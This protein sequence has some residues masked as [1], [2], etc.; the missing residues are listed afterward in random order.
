MIKTHTHVFKFVKRGSPDL[1][2]DERGKFFR[3]QCSPAERSEATCARKGFGE[4]NDAHF[5]V[6]KVTFVSVVLQR[7]A[8]L[9]YNLSETTWVPPI[10]I[11]NLSVQHPQSALDFKN[12]AQRAPFQGVRGIYPPLLINQCLRRGSPAEL[13][14]AGLRC[15]SLTITC[16][17]AKKAVGFWPTA[18]C[19]LNY[20]T[21]TVASLQS[22]S[23]VQVEPLLVEALILTQYLPASRLLMVAEVPVT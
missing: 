20:F 13:R 3:V 8:P 11:K 1:P 9:P 7:L 14:S 12:L 22:L 21:V 6:K 19:C 23:S 5:R 17:F 2:S 10:H 15:S 18:L 4:T 16:T